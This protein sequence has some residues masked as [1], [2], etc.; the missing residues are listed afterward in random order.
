ML[1]GLLLVCPGFLTDLAGAALLSLQCAASAA[2][3][4]GAGCIAAQPGDPSTVDLAPD[5]WRRCP[6]ARFRT[7]PTGAA[8]ESGTEAAFLSAMERRVSHTADRM[9]RRHRPRRVH[10]S[11]TNGGPA[12]A[13]A[14]NPAPAAHGARAIHQ[15]SLVRESERAAARCSSRPSR[16]ST[17]RSTS[18]PSR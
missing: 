7:I 15:G 14:T 3:R 4:R 11:T 1:A 16:R 8:N 2:T 9:N 10:V 18:T 17:S 12:Q 5:E 6:T 13:P